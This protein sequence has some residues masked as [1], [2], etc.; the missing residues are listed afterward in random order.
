WLEECGKVVDADVKGKALRILGTRRNIQSEVARDE[1]VRLAKS[2][3]DHTSEGVFV[4]D[5]QC[6]FLSVNPAFAG[7][8]G[9]QPGFLS[10]KRI[11]DISDTP[12][13]EDIYREIFQQVQSKDQWQ[14]ELLEKRFQGDY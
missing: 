3:V 10:G 13:R 1:Q 14:G 11:Q 2:V 12:K 6:R 5:P 9:Y 8:I 7:I 4:L